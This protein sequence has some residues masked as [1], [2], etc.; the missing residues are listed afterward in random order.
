L[1]DYAPFKWASPPPKNGFVVPGTPHKTCSEVQSAPNRAEYTSLNKALLKIIIVSTFAS[2]HVATGVHALA[3]I[4]ALTAAHT[5][6]GF[7][8]NC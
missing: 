6:A 3:G 8:A 1:C 7:T 5:I 2:I 4:L